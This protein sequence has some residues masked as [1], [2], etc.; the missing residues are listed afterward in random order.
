M[1]TML[2]GQLKGHLPFFSLIR[3]IISLPQ[4]KNNPYT[5]T[6]NH[7]TIIIIYKQIVFS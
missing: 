6:S 2:T 5:V 7:Q 4:S 3:I 1:F